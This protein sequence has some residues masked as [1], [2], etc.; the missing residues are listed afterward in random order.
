MSLSA[1]TWTKTP[2]PAAYNINTS[3]IKVHQQSYTEPKPFNS[4]TSRFNDRDNGI[5]GPGEY[6]PDLKQSLA[7]QVAEKAAI[8][9][10]GVFGTAAER[11]AQS[12][13]EEAQASKLPGPGDYV[14]DVKHEV[15]HR[16]H[17]SVSVVYM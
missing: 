4:S 2:G 13:L 3:S 1:P 11:R 7:K 16:G 15:V 5:P 9:K 17:A 10:G 6:R 12:H 14:A 8:S